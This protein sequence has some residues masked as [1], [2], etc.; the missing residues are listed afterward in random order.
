MPEG[1]PSPPPLRGREEP[2]RPMITTDRLP[3]DPDKATFVILTAKDKNVKLSSINRFILKKV[4]DYNIGNIVNCKYLASGD[5]LVETRTV[6]QVKDLLKLRFIHDIEIEASIPTSMNSCRGVVTSRDFLDSTPAQILEGMAEQNVVEVRHITKMVDG[7]RRNTASCILT[8]ASSKLPDSVFVVYD[9][10]YV[11]PYIPNPLRCFKCQLFG[12]H[13]NACRST[14]SFCGKCGAEG[15]AADACPSLVEKCRNCP[16]SHSSSSR[17]CPSWKTEK[18]VCAVKAE[19][20]ISYGE[21]RRHVKEAQAQASP[22]PSVTYANAVQTRP[23]MCTIATQTEPQHDTPASPDPSSTKT[24]T[25]NTSSSSSTHTSTS[26]STSTPST[27]EVSTPSTSSNPS[28][29]NY[30]SVVS[31]ENRRNEKPNKRDQLKF[32]TLRPSNAA[33]PPALSRRGSHARSLSS[34]SGGATHDDMEVSSGKGRERSPG[35]AGKPKHK[36]AK[37]SRTPNS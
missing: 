15:H 17:D 33:T 14:H 10:V 36:K 28:T 8:F 11:R 13:T 35:S 30:S 18:E 1:T 27:S 32:T 9:R 21:A 19:K 7:V 2:D 25:T 24:T 34:S 23:V 37:N 26:T 20:G 6:T 4:M 22:S 16:G 3:I 5:L 12:H 31:T 29:T